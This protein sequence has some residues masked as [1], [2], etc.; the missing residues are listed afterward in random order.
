[1]R[2]LT[3]LSNGENHVTCKKCKLDLKLPRGKTHVCT[4]DKK[5]C[6]LVWK[7]MK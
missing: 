2:S 4:T 7:E 6:E 3:N 5:K 1:M